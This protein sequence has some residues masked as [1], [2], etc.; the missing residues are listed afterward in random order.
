LKRLV[1]IFP[2]RFNPATA[3]DCGDFGRGTFIADVK[4]AGGE[5]IFAI[6]VFGRD[7]APSHSAMHMFEAPPGITA[8]L[9]VAARTHHRYAD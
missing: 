8:R 5:L 6:L 1:P 3:E 9:R 4:L 2:N 7:D